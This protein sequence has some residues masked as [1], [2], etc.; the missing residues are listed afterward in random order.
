MVYYCINFTFRFKYC[1]AAYQ[2]HIPIIHLNSKFQKT[3]FLQ[4]LTHL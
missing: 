4:I 3:A 2:L 1:V